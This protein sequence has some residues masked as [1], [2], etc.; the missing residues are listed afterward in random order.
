MLIRLNLNYIAEEVF[1]LLEQTT[2]R[3][4]KKEINF[5]KG[6]FLVSANAGELHQVLLNL[7]TNST[8]SIEE[9]GVTNNDFIRINAK[10][11]QAKAADRTGLV[12]GDYVHLSFKDTGCGI[13]DQVRSRVFE[14]LFT[15]KDK[16][17]KR[18]Q[19]GSWPCYGV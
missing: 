8:H 7:A 12:A 1:G 16:G 5:N 17:S 9:R 18:G 10:Y 13:P 11:Y 4:I 3:L 2:D 15:T 19:G 6:E 14:P